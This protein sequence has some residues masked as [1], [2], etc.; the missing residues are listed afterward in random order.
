MEGFEYEAKVKDSASGPTD[1]ATEAVKKLGEALGKT[2]DAIKAHEKAQASL[3]K[4]HE[5]AGKAAEHGA[6][7]FHEFTSSLIPEI[8]VAELLAEG[9]KKLG[10]AVVDLTIEGAKFALEA[11]DFKEDTIAAYSAIYGSAEEGEKAFAQIESMA[12][13]THTKLEDAGQMAQNLMV[14]G[15]EDQNSIASVIE[16]TANLRRIGLES[17]AAKLSRI[18]EQS[19][20]LGHFQLPKKLAG[21]GIRVEEV[22]N[23]LAKS[24][25]KTPEIIKQELK[26]GKIETEAGIAAITKVINEGKI[27]QIAEKKFDLSD[28]KTDWHNFW[29]KIFEDVNIEPLVNSL[30][31]FAGI[32]DSGTASGKT[33]HDTITDAFN[34]IMSVGGQVIDWFTIFSLKI[35]LGF[36]EGKLAAKPMREELMKMGLTAPSLSG[37]GDALRTVAKYLTEGGIAAAYVVAELSKLGSLKDSLNDLFSGN[38]F[39]NFGASIGREVAPAH[40]SGGRVMAP[41]P[42][43]FFTSVAPGESILPKGFQ[44]VVPSAA[45]GHMGGRGGP[46]QVTWTGDI[47][48]HEAHSV[49]EFKSIAQEEIADMFE[50]VRDELGGGASGV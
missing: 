15:I 41:P 44:L 11:A 12:I 25:H 39:T 24:L 21:T 33:F 28:L 26:A 16:A 43:E 18:V 17:G 2:D 14:A 47:I 42:G 9:I 50:R 22:V 23:E 45:A 37:V 30:R 49:S 4:A 3:G 34:A 5:K 10:E 29:V 31:G 40:A 35:V 20:A 27:G 8:A 1:A 36:E 48:V 6:G 46:A 7:F 13:G 19:A 38:V 32:F